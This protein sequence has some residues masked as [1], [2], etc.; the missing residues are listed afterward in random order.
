M[1]VSIVHHRHGR[2]KDANV[3]QA[4]LLRDVTDESTHQRSK[5][6]ILRSDRN[7]CTYWSGALTPGIYSLLPFS[8]SFWHERRLATD[9]R[10]TFTIVLHS[11]VAI[12]GVLSDESSMYLADSLLS[13]VIK[14]DPSGGEEV[15]R[16]VGMNLVDGH[17]SSSKR[18]SCMSLERSKSFECWSPRI[19]P[20]RIISM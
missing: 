10:N 3:T 14:E 1:H 5:T 20:K 7:P 4:F 17:C 2:K 12:E 9:F 16:G 6:S 8:I 18:R 15:R 19:V 11:G 13:V